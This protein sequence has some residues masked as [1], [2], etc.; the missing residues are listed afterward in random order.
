MDDLQIV[1]IFNSR[2]NADIAKNILESNGIKAMISGDDAGG[3]RPD[4]LMAMGG[5]KLMVLQKDL[6]KAVEILD[7]HFNED[8]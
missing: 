4:F 7:A 2:V 3:M 8:I 6:E 5:A 1:K